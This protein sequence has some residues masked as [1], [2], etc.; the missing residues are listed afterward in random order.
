MLKNSLLKSARKSLVAAI[1]L[2]AAVSLAGASLVGAEPAV[3]DPVQ[4]ECF[5]VVQQKIRGAVCAGDPHTVTAIVHARNGATYVKEC[6]NK[7]DNEQAACVEKYAIQ[8]IDQVAKT[9]PSSASKF[10]SKLDSIIKADGG[11]PDK[12]HSGFGA[13]QPASGGT[14]A[15]GNAKGTHQCGG[16]DANGKDISVK[17][18][19]DF[20][21]KGEGNP[22]ADATFAIIRVLSNGVGLV[23]IGS[24]VYGGIQYSA[25]RGDPQATA[26]AIGRLR[27][28]VM[29]L[30]IFIFGY[31][32]LNYIIPAG[33]LG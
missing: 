12:K 4:S 20:G 10:N 26:M 30:I 2:T 24:L 15:T 22:I 32:L 8:Y 31:A 25:S 13:L 27:S 21:C 9:K 16:R 3:S 29:A 19:I 23:I 5:S 33:F 7:P 28:N 1:V 18:S 14:F 6:I 17:T 11:N